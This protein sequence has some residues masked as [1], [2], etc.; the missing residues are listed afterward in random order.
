MITK[1]ELREVIIMTK[2]MSTFERKMKDKKFKE[3]Y[4]KRYKEFLFSELLIAIMEDD[5]ISVRELAKEADISPS[6]IQ[7]IRSGKQKDI[8]VSNLI[9]IAHIF[10]YDVLL[11]KG[12]ETFALSDHGAGKSHHLSVNPVSPT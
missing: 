12:N 11:Q 6:V 1:R 9:K 8:K 10:G 3:A 5:N 7:N 4:E 2:K